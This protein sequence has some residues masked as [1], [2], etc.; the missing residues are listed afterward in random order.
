MTCPSCREQM[1]SIMLDNQEILHCAN[2][3]SSFFEDNGINRI[4]IERARELAKERYNRGSAIGPKPT[5]PRDESQLK[6]LANVESIPATVRL[7]QCPQCLGILA[8]ADDLELFKRAQ[9]SKLDYFKS[10]NLPLGSLRGVLAIG[11]LVLLSGS[12]FW[13]FNTL[14]K[15]ATIRSEA[16]GLIKHVDVSQTD[17]YIFF[18]FRTKTPVRATLIIE[19]RADHSITTQPM[20]GDLKTV[21]TVSIPR[22]ADTKLIFYRVR[23]EDADGHTVD[24]KEV[25]VK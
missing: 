11:L 6:L 1:R 4:G 13:S 14:S 21:H 17:S 20:S 12:L 9:L 8:G 10:W 7:F 16:A 5:C 2:C 3:G 15:E 22:P 23:L 19:N 25:E 18:S 24:T